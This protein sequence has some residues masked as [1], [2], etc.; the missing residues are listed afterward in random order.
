MQKSILLTTFP[1]TEFPGAIWFFGFVSGKFTAVVAVSCIKK[2]TV[3]K[4]GV[5]S[6]LEKRADKNE[7]KEI[8]K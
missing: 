5:F 1:Q 7:T 2:H 8:L 3:S 6:Q 4:Y